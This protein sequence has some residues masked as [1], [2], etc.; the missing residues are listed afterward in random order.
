VKAKQAGDR[1]GHNNYFLYRAFIRRWKKKIYT[2]LEEEEWISQV[3]FGVYTEDKILQ[4]I[5]E[6]FKN[7]A[8]QEV[9]SLMAQEECETSSAPR[10]V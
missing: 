8:V 9:K 5:V 10:I 1:S 7:Q 6:R 4:L 2:Y 3:D